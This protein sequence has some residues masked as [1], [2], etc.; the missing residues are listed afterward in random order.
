MNEKR[1]MLAK[2][3]GETSFRVKILLEPEQDLVSEL[4]RHVVLIQELQ[5]P[6]PGQAFRGTGTQVSP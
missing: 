4:P 2:I 5:R 6:I 1:K 3:V